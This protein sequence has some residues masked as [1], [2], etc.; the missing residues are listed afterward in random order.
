MSCNNC[1]RLKPVNICAT[2]LVIGT[3]ENTDEEYNIIFT[4]LANGFKVRYKADSDVDGLLTLTPESGFAL[5]TDMGYEI[6]VN[7]SN[8][9]ETGDEF[10][11]GTVAD[12][13]FTLSFTRITE[14]LNDG[15]TAS[16][17]IQTLELA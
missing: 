4:S 8:S 15:Q 5:A 11:I 17:L 13:C 3:V 7:Q 14:V 1:T 2:S 6:I 12:D 16:T 10:T 9:L